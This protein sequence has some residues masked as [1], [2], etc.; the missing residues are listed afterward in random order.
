MK[1]SISVVFSQRYRK[2]GKVLLMLLPVLILAVFI[3]FGIHYLIAYFTGLIIIFLILIDIAIII[4]FTGKYYNWIFFFLSVFITAIYFKNNRWPLSGFLFATGFSG[5]IL[6]SIYSAYFFWKRYNHIKFLKYIGFS[7]S[8]VLVIAS[9]GILW[10]MN[11]WPMAGIF[12]NTGM[13]VFIPFLFVFVFALPSSDYIKWSKTD[14][15][16]FFRSVIIPM[17]F[18][19]IM[20]MLMF[21]LN[22][23]WISLTRSPLTPFGMHS[24]DLFPKPGI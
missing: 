22:D 17:V 14:R 13:I 2:H 9:I 24:I 11:H 23:L 16:V 10:K 8:I 5:I 20:C 6:F 21:V 7:S 1:E 3:L 18:V 4:G 19:Y 15:T 12:L